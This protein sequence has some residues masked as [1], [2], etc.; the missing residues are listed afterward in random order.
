[1]V[2]SQQLEEKTRRCIRCGFCLDACPTF[3]LTGQETLSPRGRIYLARGWSRGELPADSSMLHALDTCL[4]CRACETACPSGVEYGSILEMAR[5]GLE[6][7]NVRPSLQSNARKYFLQLLTTPSA[8]AASLQA[9]G[10]LKGLTAGKMPGFAAKLLSGDPNSNLKLPTAQGKPTVH[11]LPTVSKAHGENRYR[12]GIL[13]GC[14]MRVLFG[15]T[16]AATVRV[17]QANGCEVICPGDACCCGALHSHAGMSEDAELRMKNLIDAFQPFMKDIDAIVVNSAGCGSSMKEYGSHQSTDN[18]YAEKARIL[19]S[20]VK[21]IT[22][23]LIQIGL[24]IPSTPRYET[25]SYHDACHLAHGQKIREQPRE[26]LKSLPGINVVEMSESDTCCGSAGIY[27]VVQPELAS[28]LLERKVS[29][30]RDTGATTIVTGNPGCLAWIKQG[31]EEAGL[32][33]SILHPVDLL[34][35]MYAQDKTQSS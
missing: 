11:T 26:I 3:R 24:V 10:L 34:D 23:W 29:H 8:L 9:A 28:Q 4:G 16:N 21:D 33:I 19:S 17:L 35:A 22:E 6:A 25:V 27:N 18:E 20:K 14:V 2:T 31:V 1:M 32:K 15:E 12:V 13:Q 5:S 7:A 30:I